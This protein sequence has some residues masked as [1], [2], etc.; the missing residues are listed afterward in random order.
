MNNS[1]FIGFLFSIVLFGAAIGGV[2]MLVKAIE[3]S[4]PEIEEE[5]DE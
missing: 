5:D 2:I 3:N 4:H 1:E